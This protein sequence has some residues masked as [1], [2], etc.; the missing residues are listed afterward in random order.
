MQDEPEA[1][2]EAEQRYLTRQ[3]QRQAQAREHAHWLDVH[4][5]L[6]A[7]LSELSTIT[8]P[9]DIS[10]DVRGLQHRADKL[11]RRVASGR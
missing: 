3:S 6:D 1:V 7:C 11:A 8:L 9:V 10:G 4:A 2:S 5:R